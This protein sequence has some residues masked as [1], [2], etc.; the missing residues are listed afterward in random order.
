MR[1]STKLIQVILNISFIFIYGTVF[2]KAFLIT[3]II[4]KNKNLIFV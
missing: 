4:E 1:E 2:V 3:I